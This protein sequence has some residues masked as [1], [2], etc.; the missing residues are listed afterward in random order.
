MPGHAPLPGQADVQ[1]IKRQNPQAL[2]NPSGGGSRILT[3][4]N[5]VNEAG[6]GN[7]RS[8]FPLRPSV[9]NP[10]VLGPSRSTLV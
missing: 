7:R 2:L 4:A 10:M 5:E 1:K 6:T 8:L 9:Q 3:E